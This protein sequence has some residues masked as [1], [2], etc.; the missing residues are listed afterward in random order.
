LP[1]VSEVR[2]GRGA[3]RI[4][5][6]GVWL[7]VL[8]S[9]FLLLP[10]GAGAGTARND[11]SRLQAELNRAAAAYNAALSRYQ[12]LQRRSELA[13]ARADEARAS[14]EAVARTTRARARRAYE[15]G[16]SDFLEA[17]LVAPD[18]AAVLNRVAWLNWIARGDAASLALLRKARAEYRAAEKD[19]EAALARERA[20][21]ERAEALRKSLEG[22]LEKARRALAAESARA[23]AVR[24]ARVRI[25]GNMACP[26]A[27]PHAFSNDW[28]APRRGHRHRG[29]DIF[30]PY[31]TPAVAITSG[32]IKYLKTG[33]AGGIML[34]LAGDDGNDY[35]Y[36]HLAGYAS[37]IYVGRRVG[38]GEVVAY[39]GNT[40]NARGGTPHLHF[41]IHPG[42]GAAIN[43]YPILVQIC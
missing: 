31:G 32:A 1:V 19:L 17:L 7:G 18:L 24:P 34:W 35:F 23:R 27:G 29:T 42:G 10:G 20:A 13:R 3:R 22:Q 6:R 41:E 5:R 36:A 8:A 28:G 30:A 14:Y 39:V 33:G 2:R 38:T 4:G 16:A 9:F 26:V 21:L 40:G 11:V 37:G 25:T 12:E 43:P 15:V